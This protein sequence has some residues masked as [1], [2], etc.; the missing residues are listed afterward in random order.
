MNQATK[1]WWSC[2]IINSDI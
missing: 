2:I 1:Y